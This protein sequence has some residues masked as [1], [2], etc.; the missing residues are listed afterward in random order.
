MYFTGFP[1]SSI[2][3]AETTAMVSSLYDRVIDA[4]VARLDAG[5]T[6]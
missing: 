4:A 2:D 5:V 1:H 3:A 6:K